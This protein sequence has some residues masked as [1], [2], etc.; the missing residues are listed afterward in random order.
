[1]K[2][3]RELMTDEIC[4]M[5][6]LDY[7]FCRGDYVDISTTVYVNWLA[8]LSDSDFLDSY[9]SV[10]ETDREHSLADRRREE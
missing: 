9:N 8:A 5:G 4:H 6:Y 7:S 1:M 10:R 2:T 3:L